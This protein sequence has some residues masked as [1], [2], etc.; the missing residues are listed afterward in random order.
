MEKEFKDNYYQ[1]VKDQ[2]NIDF[3]TNGFWQEEYCRLL[4]DLFCE[5]AKDPLLTP[6]DDTC[7][8]LDV[9]C[10][11]G[12]IP[13]NMKKNYSDIFKTIIGVDL[14]NDM[15]SKGRKFFNMSSD[16]L[17]VENIVEGLKNIK[18]NSVD[19][20]H[21]SQVLEHLPK[22]KS[23]FVIS[24]FKR[25]LKKDGLMFLSYVAGKNS[26]EVKKIKEENSDPTHINIQTTNFWDKI[27]K[28]QKFIRHYCS[29]VFFQKHDAKPSKNGENN[30]YKEY[31]QK[32]LGGWTVAILV[33]NNY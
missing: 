9:G 3:L 20:L 12:L 24:E 5:Y 11:C 29:S 8:F 7:T 27:F 14:S 13:Y 22:D 1:F 23:N 30:F 4:N 21:C 33:N 16:E 15:I 25:V 17:M 6:I 2:Y 18:D 26:N 10:A 32:T 19:F 31:V 28:Q